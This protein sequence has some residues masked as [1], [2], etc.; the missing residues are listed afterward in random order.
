VVLALPGAL[1][2]LPVG[3]LAR[4]VAT[5]KARAIAP[6]DPNTMYGAMDV[7]ASYK[8]IV[9]GFGAPLSYIL[10]FMA[11]WWI[12]GS[13]PALAFLVCLP[14]FSYASIRVLEKGMEQL[15][16]LQAIFHLARARQE[17]NSLKQIRSELQDEVHRLVE[18]LSPKERGSE[19]PHDRSIHKEMKLRW[20]AE[21]DER[22]QGKRADS[23]R[24]VLYRRR[25]Y[26]KIDE[27]SETMQGAQE[28]L[29]DDEFL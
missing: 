29:E 16:L 3:L 22:K 11:A 7:I 9:A 13:R 8:I 1:L 25:S 19:F 28:A 10:Y 15:K 27:L 5:T 24:P 6:N 26:K 2:N 12:W 14:F 17:F 20:D 18:E 23:S 21:K 4:Y